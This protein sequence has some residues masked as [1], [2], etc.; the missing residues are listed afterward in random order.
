MKLEQEVQRYTSGKSNRERTDS[1][2]VARKAEDRMSSQKRALEM[3]KRMLHQ[4]Q[5]EAE[6]PEMDWDYYGVQDQT[7]EQPQYVRGV[8]NP[9]SVKGKRKEFPKRAA[10]MPLEEESYS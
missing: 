2:F 9:G 1:S 6:S 7:G 3:A 5:G 4:G 10:S 8:H